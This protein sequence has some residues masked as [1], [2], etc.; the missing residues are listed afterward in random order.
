MYAHLRQLLLGKL[1][2]VPAD[3]LSSLLPSL[4]MHPLYGT[5]VN[6]R[7]RL[8]AT[9]R[10][11]LSL[12]APERRGEARLLEKSLATFHLSTA[13][14]WLREKQLAQ[15]HLAIRTYEG[16]EC[17]MTLADPRIRLPHAGFVWAP[18]T[19]FHVWCARKVCLGAQKKRSYPKE[20]RLDNTGC[21]TQQ[22]YNGEDNT[23]C[24]TQQQ[25]RRRKLRTN[26]HTGRC[27]VP[28]LPD[29]SNHSGDQDI[30][31]RH[32]FAR[33]GGE[34]SGRIGLAVLPATVFCLSQKESGS[35]TPRHPDLI[36][37]ALA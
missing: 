37:T 1:R 3:R 15:I 11:A 27:R 35:P 18:D 5:T 9:P 31:R 14:P 24:R 20:K 8:S 10:R 32:H 33:K 28:C 4:H 16:T 29:E 25:Q 23:G 2:C 30:Q 17:R 36:R 21:R 22:Q 19:A 12:R 7:R 6:R 34:K 26:L 13:A